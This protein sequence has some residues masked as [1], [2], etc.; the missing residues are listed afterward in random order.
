MISGDINDAVEYLNSRSQVK[1]TE[2]LTNTDDNMHI[3]RK[4]L[5]WA[6]KDAIEMLKIYIER[7]YVLTFGFDVTHNVL[8]KEKCAQPYLMTLMF[9][10]IDTGK[11][12]FLLQALIEGEDATSIGNCLRLHLAHNPDDFKTSRPPFFIRDQLCEVTPTSN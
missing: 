8:S 6:M 9:K 4:F 2:I 12:C 10:N 3:G 1:R 7:D 11:F 5:A